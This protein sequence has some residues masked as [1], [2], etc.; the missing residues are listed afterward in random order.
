MI[1]PL[2]KGFVCDNYYLDMLAVVVDILLGG[3]AVLNH[4]VKIPVIND[5][6]SSRFY[7]GRKMSQAHFVVPK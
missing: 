7:H 1:S 6:N 2:G 5:E 3:M 4:V